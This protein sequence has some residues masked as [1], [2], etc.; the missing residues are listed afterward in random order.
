MDFRAHASLQLWGRFPTGHAPSLA[1]LGMCIS[2]R[3][4][5]SKCASESLERDTFSKLPAPIALR[6]APELVLRSLPIALP[7]TP[8]GG[9]CQHHR[10]SPLCLSSGNATRRLTWALDSHCEQIRWSRTTA[11]AVSTHRFSHNRI[12]YNHVSTSTRLSTAHENAARRAPAPAHALSLTFKPGLFARSSLI[13]E[14]GP[15]ADQHRPHEALQCI[16]A[17][18]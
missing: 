12:R 1:R 3:P 10:A 13:P 17:P 5:P 18:L 6:H 15:P 16:L 9:S 7:A 2:V 14:R 4:E 11:S 8:T